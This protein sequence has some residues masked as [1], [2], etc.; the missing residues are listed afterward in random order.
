M[1]ALPHISLPVS[2]LLCPQ[3]Q[4]MRKIRFLN[5]ILVDS[6]ERQ[7]PLSQCKS[8][9]RRWIAFNGIFYQL[10]STLHMMYD[11]GTE[12]DENRYRITCSI[13]TDRHSHAANQ[14]LSQYLSKSMHFK[15]GTCWMAHHS[16]HYSWRRSHRNA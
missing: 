1:P 2:L 9:Q 6:R 16:I 13:C 15:C 4:S 12:T 7:W 8:H 10:F 5:I 3:T 11:A 14:L